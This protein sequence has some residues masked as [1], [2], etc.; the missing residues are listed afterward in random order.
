MGACQLSKWLSMGASQPSKLLDRSVVPGIVRMLC[1]QLDFLL[2]S[3][4]SKALMKT[5]LCCEVV[6]PG[7]L[8]RRLKVQLHVVEPQLSGEET[9]S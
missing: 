1:V 9:T 4:F 3:N 8:A 7:Q 6:H 2:R 5:Q